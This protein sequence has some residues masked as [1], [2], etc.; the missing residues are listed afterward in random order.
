MDIKC[1]T[2][3]QPWPYA[4]FKLGKDVENRSWYTN[5]RGP[6][7]IHAAQ[8][9]DIGACHALNIDPRDPRLVTGAILGTVNLDENVRNS[10]STWAERGSFHWLLSSA[11][12]FRVPIRAAGRLAIYDVTLDRRK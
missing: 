10:K 9:I 8:R 12:R 1:I 11:R 6:L 7:A 3:R 4:I 5:Y 2:L